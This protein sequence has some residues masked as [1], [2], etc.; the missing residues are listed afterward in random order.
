[1]LLGSS[2]LENTRGNGIR[3]GLGKV[4]DRF[5]PRGSAGGTQRRSSQDVRRFVAEVVRLRAVRQRKSHD[6]RYKKGSNPR[7]SSA[8]KLAIHRLMDSTPRSSIR[9][10]AKGGI[11]RG[12]RWLM[13]S[14]SSDSKG[15]PGITRLFPGADKWPCFAG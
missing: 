10:V 15:A 9:F 3:Q 11:W 6:F 14:T 1:M 8:F 4:S 7:Y 5:V 13:R 12:P 2:A